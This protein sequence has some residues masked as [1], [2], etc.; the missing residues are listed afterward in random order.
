MSEMLEADNMNSMGAQ[1]GAGGMTAGTL[2]RQARQAA[3]VHVAALAVALKVPAHKLEALEED[4]YEVFTDV[5]F[6]R[7]LASSVCRTLK[8]DAAPVL[9]LLPTSSAPR[10]AVDHGINASFKDGSARASSAS[11]SA[12]SRSVI[13]VVLVLLLAALAMVFV[14]RAVDQ[15]ASAGKPATA[16]PGAVVETPAAAPAEA[17]SSA[18]AAVAEPSQQ[19]AA[20]A[21]APAATPAPTPAPA[22]AAAS[23]PAVVVP[24]APAAPSVGSSPLAASSQLSSV[25]VAAADEG[26]LVI[27]ASGTSWVQVRSLSGGGTTQ[28]TLTAGDKLVA[29]GSPPWAVVIGKADATTVTVRGKPMD[30]VSIARENVA[31]FEVK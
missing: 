6:L 25:P 23:V 10:L 30:V 21:P 28:K 1:P 31:R 14:P 29:P 15:S 18:V 24:A 11:G 13:G 16:Q 4:R 19:P 12:I 7:A 8:V 5:V 9:A 20:A 2:L 22:I 17:A 3:G 26:T 27:T